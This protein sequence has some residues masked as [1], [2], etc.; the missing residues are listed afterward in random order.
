MRRSRPWCNHP[1]VYGC[2][3]AMV[4][5]AKPLHDL[6]RDE[7]LLA[8]AVDN[9]LQQGTLY[10]HLGMEEMLCLL[11]IFWFL[12]LDLHGGNGGI[13]LCIDNDSSPYHS[14]CQVLIQSWSMHLIQKPSTQ[15]PVTAWPDTHLCCEWSSYGTHTTSP[16][17]FLASWCCSLLV[18]LAGCRGLPAL[19]WSFVLW[20]GG[21]FPLLLICR[22][23]VSLLLF[24]LL[25]NL[26]SI[27]V[28]HTK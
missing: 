15:L 9:E 4:G 23:K 7:V 26:G 1:M 24:E 21:T 8:P 22:P 2:G 27:S 20:F 13:G 12:L 5:Q 6:Y 18:A 10:P 3:C 19:A 14:P 25:L 16:C 28:C 11:W 17:P